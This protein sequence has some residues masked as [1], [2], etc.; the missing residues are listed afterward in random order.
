M[1]IP[2]AV[3]L[4]GYGSIGQ[5][6][7]PLLFKHFHFH[8][9]QISVIA[10]DENGRQLAEAYS[11]SYSNL[12]LTNANYKTVLS[13]LLKEGDWVINVSV[14][15][16]SKA[17]IAWCQKVGVLY[18]DTCVEPW[19]GGYGDR[20]NPSSITNYALRDDVLRM[21]HKG[22]PTAVV[23]HGANPGLVSHFIKA[24]LLELAKLKNVEQ[25][26]SWPALAQELDIKVIQI[27]ERDTQEADIKLDSGDF[28][29]TWSVDG[30]LAEA[31]QH[32]EMGWGSHEQ[33]FPNNGYR[34]WYG[35]RSG[36]YLGAHSAEVAIRSWVPDYQ[37][38]AAY[39]IAHHEALSIANLLTVPGKTKD[40]PMYRPTV[41]FAYHPSAVTCESLEQWKVND[42][43]S[44]RYKCVTREALLCGD[45][46]LGVL[47]VYPG[48]S[49]WYGS[50]LTLEEARELAPHNNAT[51]LQVVAG[52]LGGLAWMCKHP[53]EG[54]IEAESMD[55]VEVLEVA[56]PYL[57]KVFGIDSDWQPRDP[58]KLQF[59]DFLIS[60]KLAPFW[61]NRG[62]GQLDPSVKPATD[63]I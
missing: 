6:L 34:H 14:E 31:W 47:F 58:G 12:P 51:T 60:E 24:G 62:S 21:R 39:L 37:E 8:P 10:A 1:H 59:S 19:S 46:Q 23:A 4:I 2:S 29:N 33:T 52:I 40:I 3:L 26:K 54:V 38:Q 15:V 63:V 42:Y 28:F 50:K 30:L 43:Q 48:G 16:S 5:A 20:C 53:R 13:G 35:D 17:L 22:M 57:G 27:A 49:Y 9:S 61:K 32:A 11:L 44:P 41:Y 36:I 7:T 45:D 25:W 55:F 18:L 56:T